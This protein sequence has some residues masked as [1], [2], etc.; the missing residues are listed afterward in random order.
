MKIPLSVGQFI[1]YELSSKTAH[2]D[3]FEVLH[4]ARGFC[5]NAPPNN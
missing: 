1:S 3:F 4:K 5:M 2:Q